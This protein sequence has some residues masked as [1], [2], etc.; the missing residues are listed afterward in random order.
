MELS[1]NTQIKL[2]EDVAQ[3]KQMVADMKEDS[4]VACK[5]LETHDGRIKIL[6]AYKNEMVGRISIIAMV[7]GVVGW[8]ITTAIGYFLDKH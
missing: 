4:K 1:E 6:E 8:A 5:L 2:I 7:C 3:I